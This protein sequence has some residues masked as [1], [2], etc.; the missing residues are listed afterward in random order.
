MTQQTEHQPGCPALGGYGHG[1]G[2]CACS[3]SEQAVQWPEPAFYADDRGYEVSAEWLASDEATSD[4]RDV[5]NQPRYTEQQ[6]RAML[7][8]APASDDPRNEA[9]AIL[10]AIAEEA[11]IS[12]N[13]F[14]HA[15]VLMAASMLRKGDIP[16]P[17]VLQPLTAD[18]LA[19]KCEMWLQSGGASNIVDAFEAG[20]REAERAHR[21]G[22]PNAD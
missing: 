14:A 3:A 18:G 21:I 19:D 17:P 22:A 10:E 6:V 7:Q 2:P 8:A 13:T 20:Y 16:S 15:R 5:Y 12:G 1:K 4:Y 11:P 9:A